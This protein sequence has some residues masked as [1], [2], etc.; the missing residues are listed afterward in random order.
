[1]ILSWKLPELQQLF[2]LKIRDFQL[3]T[4]ENSENLTNFLMKISPI[5]NCFTPIWRPAFFFIP[6]A[7]RNAM[8]FSKICDAQLFFPENSQNFTDFSGKFLR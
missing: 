2:F 8:V 3:F 7:S 6:E 4:A 5:V 1:M